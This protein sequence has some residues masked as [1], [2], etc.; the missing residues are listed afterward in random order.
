MQNVLS[1]A[2]HILRFLCIIILMRK[3]EISVGEYYHVYNRGNNKQ[4]IFLDIRDYV[5]FLFLIIY[6]Q[7]TFSFLNI[8]RSVSF[9]VKRNFF[10]FKKDQLDLVIK[11]RYVELINFCLMPNHF[12]LTLRETKEGGISQYMHRI[13]TSFTKY[14]NKKYAKTGHLFQGT[15]KV[16]HIESNE[17]LLYLSAY[18]HRNPRGIKEWKNKEEKYPW[19]SF[20]DYVG[21]SRWGNLLSYEIIKGQFDNNQEYKEFNNKSGTK[22]FGED[23]EERDLVIDF[24]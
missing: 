20:Q 4:N 7:S 10:Y 23:E 21:E 2:L 1:L 11:N 14:H 18:I 5:R 19:S 24:E 15:F 6:F 3:V 9:F 22:D 12:H 16:V 13:G 8:S 17:Q